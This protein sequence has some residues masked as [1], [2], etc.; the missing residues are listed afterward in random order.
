MRRTTTQQD[1]DGDN[2]KDEGAA[3]SA[4]CIPDQM[5]FDI[6]K[7]VGASLL[8]MYMVLIFHYAKR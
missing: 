8:C 4:C 2:G 5:S 7:I 6:R 3:M 1:G